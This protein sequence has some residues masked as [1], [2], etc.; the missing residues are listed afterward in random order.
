MPTPEETKER[1]AL[2]FNTAA[3][4]FDNSALG[5][6]DYFGRKT[7]PSKYHSRGEKGI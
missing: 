5:F 3:D 4:N 6:W 2:A 7:E 1:T